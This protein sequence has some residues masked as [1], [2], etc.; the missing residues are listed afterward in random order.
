MISQS[1]GRPGLVWF[2]LVYVG[3][4]ISDSKK[5]A[6]NVR[7]KKTKEVLTRPTYLQGGP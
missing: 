2:G 3:L 6:L 5:V 4:S 7:G 1:E